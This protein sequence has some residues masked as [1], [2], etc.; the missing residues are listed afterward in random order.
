MF[1]QSSTNLISSSHPCSCSPIWSLRGRSES[2]MT[3]GFSQDRGTGS[4]SALFLVMTFMKPPGDR[5]LY[6][7]IRR[8]N[9]QSPIVSLVS[10][11]VGPF[12]AV[13]AFSSIMERQESSAPEEDEGAKRP[14]LWLGLWMKNRE[15]NQLLTLQGRI[16]WWHL[17]STWLCQQCVCLL[18]SLELLVLKMFSFFYGGEGIG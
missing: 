10:W 18:P 15:A 4:H 11:S 12:V 5:V 7:G 3:H 6:L 16:S 13:I 2:T 9:S 8:C 1:Q 14:S 17:F